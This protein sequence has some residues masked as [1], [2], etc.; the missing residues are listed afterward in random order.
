[1]NKNYSNIMMTAVM[2]LAA[3]SGLFGRE[4]ARE[5][6]V[7]TDKNQLKTAVKDYILS[8]L[9]LYSA[10]PVVS[11]G[12]IK[13]WTGAPLKNSMTDFKAINRDLGKKLLKT[14]PVTASL[15]IAYSTLQKI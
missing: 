10:I 1:M 4:I 7:A 12:A 5:D 3:Y 2:C 13:L 8:H 11:A 14:M 15:V 6:L 9:V